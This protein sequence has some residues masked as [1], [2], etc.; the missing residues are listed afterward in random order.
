MQEN[1]VV[2]FLF[3]SALAGVVSVYG[4]KRPLTPPELR[5]NKRIKEIY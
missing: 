3:Y 4:R 5:N 2:N 1:A